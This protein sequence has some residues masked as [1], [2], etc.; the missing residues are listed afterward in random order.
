M[1]RDTKPT[2]SDR[3]PTVGDRPKVIYV[4]GAGRSGSTV[5]G[6]VL[7]NCEN[8]FF[9]GELEAWLR[10]SGIPNFA[11]PERTRFW[12][13]VRQRIDGRDEL[14]GEHAL[15][16]VE[17]TLSLFRW[18]AW[19]S[20]ELRRRYRDT[21]EELYRAIATLAGGTHIVDTS[22]YP[23]RA[24][25]LRRLDAIDLYL[26]YLVRDP[27][28]VVS[29]FAKRDVLQSSKGPLAANLYLLATHLLSGLVFL[30]HPRDRRVF[31]RYED[32]I[33]DPAA[34][35]S[36]ILSRMDAPAS[37]PDLTSLKTGTPFQGNRMINSKTIALQGGATPKVSRWVSWVTTAL[38]SPSSL[39]FAGLKPRARPGRA[40]IAR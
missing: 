16:R 28:G 14:F 17:H 21:M 9:A 32:F 24:R 7:G 18:S 11:E 3:R 20:R 30:S 10:R 40:P 38:Q 19:R 27:R 25:E 8:V 22:H 37:P 1:R 34:V 4:M 5:L 33:E 36:A 26:V 12:E 23:L 39:L 29:S 31:V 2:P 6:V 35:S 13:A 15:R